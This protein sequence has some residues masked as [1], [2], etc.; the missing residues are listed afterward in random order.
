MNLIDA[1]AILP[2]YLEDGGGGLGVL[3]ILRLAR[4]FRLFKAPALSEGVTLLGNVIR[5][6]YPSLRLLT[7]FA[8]IGCILYGSIIHLCEQGTWHGPDSSSDD[9]G[10]GV[11]VWMRPDTYGTGL[12]RTPFLSIPRS[13]WWVM[14]TATTCGYGDMYPT[15]DA[16]KVVASLTM[17]SGVLVLALPITIISSN[18]TQEFEKLEDAKD[19]AKLDKQNLDMNTTMSLTQG[20]LPTPSSLGWNQSEK[21]KTAQEPAQEPATSNTAASSET[22][23]LESDSSADNSV[24]RAYRGTLVVRLERHL[25][26]LFRGARVVSLLDALVHKGCVSEAASVAITREV[27]GLMHRASSTSSVAG[28]NA[29][30]YSGGGGKKAALSTADGGDDGNGGGGDEGGEGGR[31]IAAVEWI[32]FPLCGGRRKARKEVA[33]AAAAAAAP[34][35]LVGGGGQLTG[36]PS[37]FSSADVDNAVQIVLLW[38][39]RMFVPPEETD[40]TSTQEDDVETVVETVVGGSAT[41]PSIPSS[42]PCVSRKTQ[43]PGGGGGQNNNGGSHLKVGGGGEIEQRRLASL[44]DLHSGLRRRP[45]ED[46]E[47][48]LRHR[49]LSFVIKVIPPVSTAPAPPSDSRRGSSPGST[50]V[51]PSVALRRATSRRTFR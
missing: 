12:E 28:N 15:T 50:G 36:S 25:E 27:L 5:Q 51:R 11:G 47:H 46:E 42:A 30:S 19:R 2:F 22:T 16:G 33:A 17:L 9:D 40:E 24:V 29:Q 48:E 3:R 1:L 13:M 21:K 10:S 32:Y 38:F 43:Q 49:F 6:S 39:R 20:A 31:G 8:L 23:S 37:A 18:F 44:L 45:S 26:M 14:V 34:A 35:Y 7:F 4:V 41:P